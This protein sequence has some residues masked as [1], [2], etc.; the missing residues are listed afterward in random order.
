[1]TAFLTA[2]IYYKCIPFRL[3]PTADARDDMWL[4]VMRQ[5]DARGRVWAERGYPP[6]VARR[7][8]GWIRRGH[9]DSVVHAG[10][11]PRKRSDMR[12]SSATGDDSGPSGQSQPPAPPSD[13]EPAPGDDHWCQH[14]LLAP[15]VTLSG[16]DTFIGTGQPRCPENRGIRLTMYDKYW[17]MLDFMGLWRNPTYLARKVELAGAEWALWHVREVMPMCAVD[18]VRGLYPYPKGIPYVGHKWE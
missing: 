14:C 15:C 9:G 16:S 13:P 4:H 12:S 5:R 8:R 10:K 1:M 3:L 2:P 6:P 18:K 17:K 7:S 11:Q